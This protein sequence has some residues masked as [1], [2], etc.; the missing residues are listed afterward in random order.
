MKRDYLATYWSLEDC[1]ITHKTNKDEESNDEE[2]TG[3]L[4]DT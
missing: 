1:R 2:S 3:R 4:Q